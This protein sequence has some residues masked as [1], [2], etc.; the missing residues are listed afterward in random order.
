MLPYVEGLEF[1]EIPSAEC[2]KLRLGQPAI[3]GVGIRAN[4]RVLNP[5][6]GERFE[7]R[8]AVASA[9]PTDVLCH[10][11]LTP[12]RAADDWSPLM[13]R[14]SFDGVYRLTLGHYDH[15]DVTAFRTAPNYAALAVSTA[16]LLACFTLCFS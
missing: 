6:I 5:L 15:R 2:A 1:D 3:E 4:R 7:L 13:H 10:C 9:T 11:S 12:R 8:S 16:G 14:D